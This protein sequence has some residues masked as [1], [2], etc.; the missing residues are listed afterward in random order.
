[1]RLFS[2]CRATCSQE[3]F[4]VEVFIQ[5]LESAPSEK[6]N[7]FSRYAMEP[8]AAGILAIKDPNHKNYCWSLKA[9]LIR[10]EASD[11]EDRERQARMNGTNFI[12][13]P[14]PSSKTVALDNKRFP[15]EL[16]EQ[17]KRHTA[18][19]IVAS[20]AGTVRA[21]WEEAPTEQFAS[22]SGAGSQET[23]PVTMDPGAASSKPRKEPRGN[24]AKLQN[25]RKRPRESAN[26]KIRDAGTGMSR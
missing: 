9:F 6:S 7:L 8:E 10:M 5:S 4:L 23:R 3:C 16:R 2:A 22:S 26:P 13:K 14:P 25:S 20:R 24:E 12:S 1:M 17:V 15:E 21:P 19:R 18:S 11:R